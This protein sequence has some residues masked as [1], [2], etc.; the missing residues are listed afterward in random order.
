MFFEVTSYSGPINS[1]ANDEKTTMEID[2]CGAR[3]N[4]TDVATKTTTSKL[5]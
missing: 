1:R 3:E 5:L 2:S 4:R